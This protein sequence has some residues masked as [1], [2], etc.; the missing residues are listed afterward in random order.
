MKQIAAWRLR[1][2]DQVHSPDG[3]LKVVSIEDGMSNGREIIFIQ[4]EDR[5]VWRYPQDKL[6]VQE[7]RPLVES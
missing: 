7:P 1:P 6:R 3:Y 2:G 4:L 5:W